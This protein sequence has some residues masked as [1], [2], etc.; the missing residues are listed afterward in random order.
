MTKVSGTRSHQRNQQKC[1]VGQTLS[2][3]GVNCLYLPRPLITMVTRIFCVPG[4]LCDRYQNSEGSSGSDVV[5]VS[6]CGH[7]L[8]GGH[9]H[10]GDQPHECSLRVPLCPGHSCPGGG[11]RA[12]TPR[13]TSDAEARPLA[14]VHRPGPHAGPEMCLV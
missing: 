14:P 7:C 10:V 1:L 11:P 12:K 5:P 8:V 6:L 2:E 13:T 3:G 4:T 9:P